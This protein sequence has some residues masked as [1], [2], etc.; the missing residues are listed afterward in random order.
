MWKELVKS[1]FKENAATVI[2]TAAA[3]FFLGSRFS[4]GKN[5]LLSEIQTSRQALERIESAQEQ[6]IWLSDNQELLMVYVVD[7]SKITEKSHSEMLKMTKEV[8]KKNV[9]MPLLERIESDVKELNEQLPHK[10]ERVAGS[11]GIKKK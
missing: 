4:D 9:N 3:V 2:F 6:L 10:Q 11:I 5:V 7:L 8:A 1:I